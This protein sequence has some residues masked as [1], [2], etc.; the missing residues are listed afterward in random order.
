[1][2]EK[3]QE[4]IDDATEYGYYSDCC[5]ADIIMG[6]ICAECREHCGAIEEEEE[7]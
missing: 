1:M 2:E 7:S 5:C 3:T 6:D 4:F